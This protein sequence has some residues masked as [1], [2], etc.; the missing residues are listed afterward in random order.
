MVS[1]ATALYARNDAI[2]CARSR[3]ALIIIISRCA[4]AACGHSNRHA[5]TLWAECADRDHLGHRVR[6]VRT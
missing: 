1:C 5:R 3:R 2:V 6:A 4:Y